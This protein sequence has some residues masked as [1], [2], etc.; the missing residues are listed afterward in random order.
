[1]VNI[2]LRNLDDTLGKL[3][4]DTMCHEEALEVAKQFYEDLGLDYRQPLL[5]VVNK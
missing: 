5:A 4:V 2:Y 3:E 1:M